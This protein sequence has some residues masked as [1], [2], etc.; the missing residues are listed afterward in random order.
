MCDPVSGEKCNCQNNTESDPTCQ[1]SGLP[2][3]RSSKTNDILCWMHQCSKCRDT[4]LGTPTDGHQCYKQM[5]VDSRFCIN[6]KPLDECKTKP[7][8]L[9]PGQTVYINTK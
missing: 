6:A 7:R 2:N 3:R 4:Y 8:P 9:Y 5:S 1:S